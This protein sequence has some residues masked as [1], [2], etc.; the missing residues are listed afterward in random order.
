MKGKIKSWNAAC[1]DERKQ[2]LTCLE[3]VA[4]QFPTSTL[5][6]MDFCSQLPLALD[7]SADQLAADQ[8]EA[9]ITI[10]THLDVTLGWAWKREF[11]PLRGVVL[12]LMLL[13]D[14]STDQAVNMQWPHLWQE[15]QGRITGGQGVAYV[16][17]PVVVR[18]GQVNGNPVYVCPSDLNEVLD[19]A[20]SYF[21][22]I[23]HVRRYRGICNAPLLGMGSRPSR[24]TAEKER[25]WPFPPVGPA[26]NR[27]IAEL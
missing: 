11:D 9:L 8:A 12:H 16:C 10:A 21:V 19:L 14:V 26:G 13:L 20:I 23:N 5:L 24:A 27:Q 15:W 18:R 7:H 25:R 1:R 22:N 4:Q 2:L 6:R 17:P 3:P